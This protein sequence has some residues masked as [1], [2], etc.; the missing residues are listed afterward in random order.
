MAIIRIMVL[1]QDECSTF[2]AQKNIEGM[3]GDTGCSDHIVTNL[4]VQLNT[5]KIGEE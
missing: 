3:I 4:K 1:P 5:S 2:L